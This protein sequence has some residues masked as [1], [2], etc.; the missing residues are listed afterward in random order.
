MLPRTDLNSTSYNPPNVRYLPASQEVIWFSQESGWGHLY[1]CDVASGQR[2]NA[3]TSG[4]WLVR[5]IVKVDESRR[6]R[7]QLPT[8]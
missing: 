1:L 3:I 7:L 2:K 6:F 4:N 8:V 5:D